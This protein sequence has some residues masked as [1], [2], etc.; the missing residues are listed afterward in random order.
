M[1]SSPHNA[2]DNLEA[3]QKS[4]AS[5]DESNLPLLVNNK[6]QTN[7]KTSS[8][9]WRI[10]RKIRFVPLIFLFAAT[11][12]TVALYFQPPGIKFIMRVLNLE[13][14]GGTQTPIAIPANPRPSATD[15]ALLAEKQNRKIVGLGKLLPEGNVRTVAPP[16]GAGDA[17]I[18]KLSVEEG[19]SVAAGDLLAVLDNEASLKANVDNATSNISVRRATLEQIKNSVLISSD[20]T[21]ALLQRAKSALQNAQADF[22]RT[23]TLFKRGFTTNSVLDQKL[24][25]R[26][27]AQGEVQRLTATLARFQVKSIDEQPDVV[28]AAR[29][30]DAAVSELNRAKSDLAKSMVVA[31]TGGVI[32]KIHV[33]AGERPGT[34]GILDIG[35]IKKMTADVEVYQT[36]IG[37]VVLGAL[38][39]MSAEA[40]PRKLTG[41]V[42][43]IG[44]EV[45]NQELIDSSP[46]A[47]TNAR[48]VIVTVT[49]DEPSS[50]AAKRFTNLQVLARIEVPAK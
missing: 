28:V 1:S 13:P 5:P 17:R 40:L 34:K 50:D 30:L 26:D 46:A 15:A 25:V 20:E 19:D 29:N 2:N 21:S 27:Q 47:N 44:L 37:A 23:D 11:V 10:L 39:E 48:V 8:L 22:E 24:S 12:G 49:L 3:G 36:Q 4:Q 38:V 33:R 42:T 6:A 43:K 18:A 35:N 16:F 41:T 7:G 14:G 31:P 45:A 32:L 9:P